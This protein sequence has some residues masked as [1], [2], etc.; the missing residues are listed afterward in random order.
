YF[1][2]GYSYC[3]TGNAL[4]QLGNYKAALRFYR[5]ALSYYRKTQDRADMAL[6]LWG[7]A[8]CY[9][10]I[11]IKKAYRYIIKAKKLIKGLQEVRGRILINLT[12]SH[13]RY[14]MGDVERAKKLFN[15]AVKISIK[16]KANT[17]IESFG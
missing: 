9:K 14:A 6:V 8:E 16:H 4:R 3:G 11:D 10:K 1:A 13:I 5:K 17:L 15:R 12:E 7:M 2:K